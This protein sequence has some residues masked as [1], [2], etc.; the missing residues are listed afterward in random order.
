MIVMYKTG[1]SE[2]PENGIERVDLGATAIAKYGRDAQPDA[3]VAEPGSS[4][5]P[6]M[7]EDVKKKM[8]QL[9][10]ASGET[11]GKA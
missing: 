10:L 11:H 9:R 4:E 1:G 5:K 7:L 2:Q 6:R 3:T 8:K